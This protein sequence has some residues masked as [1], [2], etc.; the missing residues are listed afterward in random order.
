LGWSCKK[1]KPGR[2]LF[3][4]TF[5]LVQ[6]SGFTP[7]GRIVGEVQDRRPVECVSF[8]EALVFCNRL[9][10]LSNLTPVYSIGGSTNPKDWGIIPDDND[11]TWNAVV[12]DWNANGYRLPTLAEWY[13]ASRAGQK[14]GE[15][16]SGK[17]LTD[18]ACI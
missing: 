17:D 10:M 18:I 7:K 12:C 13:I 6:S 3:E 4:Y 15:W 14:D 5:D 11:E 16:L 9:S 8:Y 1:A 2:K